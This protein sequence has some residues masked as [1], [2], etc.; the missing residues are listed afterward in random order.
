MAKKKSDRTI[1][2]EAGGPARLYLFVQVASFAEDWADLK[3]GDDELRALEDEIARNPTRAPVVP[4]GGGARKLRWPDPR[5]GKGKSGGYRVLYAFLPV[6]E[7][8]L[9]IA[10]WPKSEREDLECDDYNAIGKM[11]ARVQTEWDRRMS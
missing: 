8:I 2:S 1:F 5:S 7:T 10:V 9:L 6:H 4:G 11:I 3:L